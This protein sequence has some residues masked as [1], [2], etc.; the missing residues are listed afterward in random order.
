MFFYVEIKNSPSSHKHP[1][2]PCYFSHITTFFEIRLFA[3]FFSLLER[4]APFS[5][6]QK[7]HVILC[8]SKSYEYLMATINKKSVR[9][10]VDK[11]KSEFANLRDAG[12]VTDEVVA[13]MNSMLMIMDL[14]LSIFLERTTKKTN[15]NSSIPSSQTGKDDSMLGS[16]GKG[17]SENNSV[18][19][20][21]RILG[22]EK[23]ELKFWSAEAG[24]LNFG[25]QK[26]SKG[27]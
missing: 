25:L 13:L 11:L 19:P 2:N 22:F 8:Y 12:K 20:N 26:V 21:M 7:G 10:E 5:S 23:R 6:S 1:H 16:K 3:L 24:K 14:I 27:R 17:K 4:I 15:K 9:E 18:A